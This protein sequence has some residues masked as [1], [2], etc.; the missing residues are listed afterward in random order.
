MATYD[1]YKPAVIGNA[2]TPLRDTTLTLDTATE[3]GYSFVAENMGANNTIAAARI[4]STVPFPGQPGQAEIIARLYE[5]DEPQDWVTKN[6]KLIIPCSSGQLG[7]GAALSPGS[8]SVQQAV[9]NP[10]DSY[11]VG[12]AGA[13]G[14]ARYWFDTRADNVGYTL[15]G[16]VEIVDVSVVYLAA[17]PFT[18]A[19]ENIM[20]LYLESPT[21]TSSYLMDTRLTGPRWP[22][23]AV[24]AYRSRLGELNPFFYIGHDPA[25]S[26]LR[27]PWAWRSQDD[28]GLYLMDATGA[29]KIN[30][31]ITTGADATGWGFDIHYLAL[32]V[33]YREIGSLVGV[34]GLNVD[35]GSIIS[36]DGLFTYDIPIMSPPNYWTDVDMPSPT[37]TE[38]TRASITISRSYTGD[39]AVIR[40]VPIIVS[41]I[42]TIESLPTLGGI[43]MTKPVAEKAQKEK[44]P[45]EILPAIAMFSDWSTTTRATIVP[46]SQVYVKQQ[47]MMSQLYLWS[48][49]YSDVTQLII[50]DTAGTFEWAIF[51][52]RAVGAVNGRLRISQVDSGG[53]ELGPIGSMT[54]DEFFEL[55]EIIDGWR[56]VIIHLDISAVLDGAGGVTYW[57]IWSETRHNHP[58]EILCAT[59]SPGQTTMVTPTVTAPANYGSDAVWAREDIHW[60]YTADAT[61]MLGQTMDTMTGLTVTQKTQALTV[62]DA[63]GIDPDAIPSGI[64]YNSITW[65][66]LT[67]DII[68]WWGY[69][70][71]QRRD[72]TM[73]T[74][75]WETIAKITTPFVSEFDDYEPRIG[76]TSSYRIRA[77][78]KTNLTG[79]WSSTASIALA[80]PGVTGA[81]VNT[82]VLVLTT[83]SDPTRNLAY[84]PTTSRP[85]PEDFTFVEASSSTT[86]ALYG[87]DYQIASRPA[88]RGGVTFER[89]LLTN[90]IGVPEDTLSDGFTAIRDL[91][92]CAA[93]YVCVR[94]ELANRWLANLNVPSGTVR[95]VDAANHLMLARVVFTE[96]TGTPAAL[97]AD[98]PY[99]GLESTENRQYRAFALGTAA[100]SSALDLDIRMLVVRRDTDGQILC[101]IAK[102]YV[103]YPWYDETINFSSFVDNVTFYAYNGTDT[104][105]NQTASPAP[106]MMRPTWMRAVTDS[107]AG[108]GNAKVTYY[109]SYDGT[110]WTTIGTYTGTDDYTITIDNTSVFIVTSIDGW[111]CQHFTVYKAGTTTKLVDADFEANGQ[112]GTF[113]DAAGI[114]WTVEEL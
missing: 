26:P 112:A 103:D 64:L 25:T 38:G 23:E 41:A 76:V 61:L 15:N 58:W 86:M 6:K 46:A 97:D 30:I 82:G 48:G 62:T 69:Y 66:E 80:A 83:N 22:Y 34:G 40:E 108:G 90:A 13:N 70:E 96:V 57:H 16:D 87:R 45:S 20:Q 109:Y 32:E 3:V 11:C 63:C 56:K 10:S 42:D 100:M 81:N 94:D 91:A 74:D 27:G 7:T 65:T 71:L 89:V 17:G 110:S 102:P 93:P 2:F 35:A 28:S 106:V 29:D 36:A 19:P 111:V 39:E 43:K 92:W 95:R 12:I 101:E 72:T 73:E 60:Y 75:V 14:W 8:T 33:T 113:T 53:T 105:I 68:S 114:F 84:T 31:K 98:E 51:Y 37:L 99:L 44:I 18:D 50:N 55:P 79:P 24:R 78:H 52:A 9:G 21:L 4:V 107:D 59:S 5:S 77:V 104:F 88:E 1:P 47:A 67:S 49:S 85:A 54:T